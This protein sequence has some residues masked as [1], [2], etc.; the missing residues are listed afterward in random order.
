MVDYKFSTLND[1]EFEHLSIELISIDKK[2]RFETFKAGR[3][4][5]ID[6]RFIHEDGKT[7][8]IQCKHYLG[9][10]YSG[11]ISSLKAKKNGKNEMDKVKGLNP[12]KYIFTTSLSLSAKNKQEIKKLFHPY[13]KCDND[14]YGRRDLN[15]ILS[16]NPKIEK[17]YYKLWLSSTTVLDRIINSA[18]E[19][20]S[21]SLLEDMKNKAKYYVI[22]NNHDEAIKKLETSHVLV[23][24]GEAGIGKSTLAE[25]LCLHYIKE[26]FKFYDVE[27]SINEADSI[28]K[29]GEKQIFYFDDFL[30]ATYLNAIENKTDSYVM[31]FI[32]KVKKDKNKRFILT[33][34]TNIFNQ[35]IELSDKFKSQRIQSDEFIL[36]VDSLEKIERAKIL[37]NHIFFSHLDDNFKKELLINKR[38]KD[39]IK[40][41]FNPRL[42][43]FITDKN[44]INDE[45]IRVENYWAY[46]KDKIKNPKEIWENS[47]DVGIDEFGRILVVL[48]VFNG[49]RIKEEL[50]RNSY[51]KYIELTNIQPTS[52]QSINFDT[53]IKK[54]VR[55]FLNRNKFWSNQHT[56]TL[57]NPSIAD[58]ILSRYSKEI[59]KLKL[60]F[61]ILKNSSSLIVLFNLM[62]NKIIDGNAYSSILKELLKSSTSN[63]KKDYL[64]KLYNNCLQI[65]N[66]ELDKKLLHELVQNIINESSNITLIKEFEN[67]VNLFNLDEFE[68]NDFDFFDNIIFSIDKDID[69]INS[70]I[71]LYNYFNVNDVSVS[72]EL[73]DLI[74]EYIKEELIHDVESIYE[75]D[76]EFEESMNE[77]GL[78]E[79]IDGEVEKIIDDLF[80]DIENR[81]EYFSDLYINE[82]EIKNSV[83]IEDIK[84]RLSSD[85]TYDKFQDYVN[86]KEDISY[87]NNALDDIDDLFSRL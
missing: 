72:N 5:G 14:I 3:D 26:N 12:N 76:V 40:N 17:N 28:Y 2:H 24:A 1:E 45:E 65:K 68:V 20:R 6:G 7:E 54:I 69:E 33:T 15:T 30:G 56:Y 36:K 42:I 23:V 9:T 35:G 47:F 55:Y 46:V 59:E 21:E 4:G 63:D 38:Y 60:Y 67:I 29:K 37:Y 18:I 66:F 57:F 50:L 11:L 19:N 13:I 27:N 87:S 80:Y 52:F 64:I 53:V 86:D 22:T 81:I 82:E 70:V 25:N 61:E 39:V 79:V 71:N 8:I 48:T 43:E 10:G 16:Q 74:S 44:R 51:N 73:N 58:F 31:K 62:K 77:E 41:G 49:N 83:E 75:H 78:F 85:F 32:S 84:H 34:R